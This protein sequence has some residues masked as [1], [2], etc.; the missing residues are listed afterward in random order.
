LSP[1]KKDPEV[2]DPGPEDLFKIGCEVAVGRVLHLPDGATTVLSQGRRR[3]EIVEF[4][5]GDT[6]LR[7]KARPIFEPTEKT[8][9][10]E[11]LMRAVFGAL[12]KSRPA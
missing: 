7:A 6:F 4:I 8:R 3:V 12:R 2:A 1:H 5:P 11:A 10:T 9:E